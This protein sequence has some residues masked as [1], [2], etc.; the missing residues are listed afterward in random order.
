MIPTYC[1]PSEAGKASEGGNVARRLA[2]LLDSLSDQI[3]GWVVEGNSNTILEDLW[4]FRTELIAKLEA[5]GWRLESKE[6]GG[7]KVRTPE[8]Y[9]K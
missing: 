6:N 5:D 7:W 9:L 8:G 2:K 4:K 3:N 1:R